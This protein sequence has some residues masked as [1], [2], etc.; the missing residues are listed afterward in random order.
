MSDLIT[1]PA[2]SS[3]DGSITV[4]ADGYFK[5]SQGDC[6]ARDAIRMT[7][8]GRLS[9]S[10][11][12]ALMSELRQ[13]EDIAL[14]AH[15]KAENLHGVQADCP[16]KDATE[17]AVSIASDKVLRL[18]AWIAAAR[19][20]TPEDIGR[21]IRVIMSISGIGGCIN[22]DEFAAFNAASVAL[23]GGTGENYATR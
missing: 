15:S 8:D 2:P 1:L 12:C 13:A 23:M 16:E 17:K 21:Q 10:A 9:I 20:T 7:K 14:A 6:A 18:L 5:T 11:M 22:R 4:D 3:F 19:P